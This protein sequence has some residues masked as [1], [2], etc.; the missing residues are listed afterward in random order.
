MAWKRPDKKEVARMKVLSDLGNTPSAIGKMMGRDGKTISRYL[1]VPENFQD[2]EVQAL[3]AKIKEDEISDLYLL[4][5]KAKSRLHELLDRGDSKMI[6]TTAVLDRTFQQRRLLENLPTENITTRS[7]AVHLKGVLSD[8]TARRDKLLKDSEKMEA[9][10]GI[11]TNV[12]SDPSH[13]HDS[14]K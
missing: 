7:V 13:E 4:G 9:G 1:G 6:E 2:P 12:E 11:S 5:A 14:E 3:I 10:E 8:L